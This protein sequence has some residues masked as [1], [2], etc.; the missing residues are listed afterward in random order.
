ML[1]GIFAHSDDA[2]IWCGGTLLRYA[3]VGSVAV[4]IDHCDM[5]RV[6]EARCAAEVLK[7]RLVVQEISRASVV[8]MILELRPS[9]IFTHH[10]DDVHPDHRRVSAIVTAAAIE[11]K[12]QIGLPRQIF[13]CDSY[14]S[15]LRSATIEPTMLISIDNWVEGKI[16]AISMHESQPVEH[17][18]DMSLRQTA[19]WGLRVGC[20][21][22]EAFVELPLLGRISNS[23]IF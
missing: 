10:F 5:Q 22:A 13:A 6:N 9:V 15:R 19:F 14:A 3:E 23:A 18:V 20:K 4:F 11:T 12:I 16:A 1:L 17:F 21:H 8:E 2:D 7:Y